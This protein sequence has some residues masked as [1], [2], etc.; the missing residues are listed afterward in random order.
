MILG[1]DQ[2]EEMELLLRIHSMRARPGGGNGVV[3]KDS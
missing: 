1:Q 3:V 2:L